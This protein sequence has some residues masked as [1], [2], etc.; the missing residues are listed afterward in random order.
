ML[1]TQ[2]ILFGIFG[3]PVNQSLSPLMH[4]QAFAHTGFNGVY[5]AF[6]VHALPAAVNAI[7]TLA[8]GGASITIPHKEAIVDLLDG[9][10]PQAR[11]IGAVNTVVNASGR[12]VGHNTDCPAALDALQAVTVVDG[13]RVVIIGAGGTARA[14]GHGVRAAG[15]HPIIVNRTVRKGERLAAALKGEFQP[16]SQWGRVRGE[17]VI[18]TTPV[19]MYPRDERM[20][21]PGNGFEPDMVVMDVI[22]NPVKTR[23][24]QAAEKAGCRTVSGVE[25]FVRQGARQFELWTRRRAPLQVMRRAVLARLGK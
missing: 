7:R 14:V 21:V 1:D 12:L 3:N 19:G 2:T 8:M 11:R 16:L 5:L 24:L 9:V 18:N 22:Y 15:G 4:N 23:L 25:M 13:K 10:E 17:I 20:P 6:R